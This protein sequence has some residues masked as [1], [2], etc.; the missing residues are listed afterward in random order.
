M[1]K[2]ISIVLSLILV[3]ILSACSIF[4]NEAELELAKEAYQELN[5]LYLLTDN[6]ASDTYSAWHYGIYDDPFSVEE[7]AFEVSLSSADLT[8]DACSLL[9][10]FDDF[11]T[12][13]LCVQDSNEA[14]GNYSAVRNRLSDVRDSII[15]LRDSNDDEIENLSRDLQTYYTNINSLLNL[16]EDYSGS[17]NSLQSDISD[18]R[19]Q[20]NLIKDSLEFDLMS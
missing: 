2:S 18:L 9:F 13:V 8:G 19:N 20:I 1:R 12:P 10:L 5:E 6:L 4:S 3:T 11:S 14:L 15:N 7:L 16:A 17:F